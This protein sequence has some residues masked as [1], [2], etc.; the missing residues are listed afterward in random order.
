[1]QTVPPSSFFKVQV[2]SLD[3]QKTFTVKAIGIPCISDDVV[4]LKTKEIA[5]CLGLEKGDIYRANGPVDLL[6]D[7]LKS[8]QHAHR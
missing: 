2:T 1:M 4:D 6:I 3:N 5:E 7:I 8:R